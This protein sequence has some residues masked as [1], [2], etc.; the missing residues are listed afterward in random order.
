MPVRRG[1]RTG[2]DKVVKVLLLLAV[3]RISR[4]LLSHCESL[5][6]G[7]LFFSSGQTTFILGGMSEGSRVVSWYSLNLGSLDSKL[8]S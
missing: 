1:R 3:G 8:Y 2:L 7:G 6:K 4:S 5:G